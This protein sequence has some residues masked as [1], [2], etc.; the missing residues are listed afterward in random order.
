MK[1][2][3]FL[4][5]VVSFVSGCFGEIKNKDIINDLDK[6]TLEKN[7]NIIQSTL[8]SEANNAGIDNN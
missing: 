6:M 3:I 7:Q 2:I 8:I 4:L 5:I 1:R